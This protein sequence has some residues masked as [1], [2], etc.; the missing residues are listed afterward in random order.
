MIPINELLNKEGFLKSLFKS[1]PCGILI[2]D[3]DRRVQAVN[4]VLERTFGISEAEVIDQR[5]IDARL[6]ALDGTAD[7]RR[8]GANAILAV[9]LAAAHA[10]AAFRRVPLFKHLHE[11]VRQ[12]DSSAP[13]PRMPLPM[14]NMISGGLHA[15]GNLDFH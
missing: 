5:G 1:I 3:S 14:V 8:L 13:L 4:N 11:L 10:A 7:K 6:N 9:S 15:G 12:F 2:V